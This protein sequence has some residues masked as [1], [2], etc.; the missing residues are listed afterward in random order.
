MT[1]LTPPT[2]F[3]QHY[4]LTYHTI[5]H[6]IH[7]HTLAHVI[8]PHTL[9]Y[10]NHSNTLAYVNHHHILTY[11]NH[12]NTLAHVKHPIA[13]TQG[14]IQGDGIMVETHKCYLFNDIIFNCCILHSKLKL[15][16]YTVPS[17]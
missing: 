8:H 12:S 2:R 3:H 1:S 13:L 5:S 4:D 14:N 16:V 7:P 6:V 10:V 17:R 9:A 15:W 11:V